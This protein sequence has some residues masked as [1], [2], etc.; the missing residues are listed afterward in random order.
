MPMQATVVTPLTTSGV[1]KVLDKCEATVRNYA[2]SGRL[3]CTRTSSGIR[4]F[5]PQDVEQ[6]ARELRGEA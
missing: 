6:L 5:D 2:I 1:A 3:S 4:I